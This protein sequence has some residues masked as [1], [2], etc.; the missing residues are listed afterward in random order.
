MF[1]GFV[2]AS[3]LYLHSSDVTV[4]LRPLL[5]PFVRS[6]VYQVSR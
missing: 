2:N 4:R 3:A 6:D 5:R 1:K